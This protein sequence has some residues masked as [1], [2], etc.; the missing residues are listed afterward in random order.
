M[1][2]W[3]EIPN[4]DYRVSNEGRVAKQRLGALKILGVAR[5]SEGYPSVHLREN[6]RERLVKVHVLVAAAFIGPKPSALHEVN[7]KDGI[8]HNN[9]ATNLEWVTRSQ[10]SRHRYDVLHGKASGR[11]K[12]TEVGAREILRRCAAG[13]VQRVI[14]ADYGIDRTTVSCIATGKTW[15]WLDKVTP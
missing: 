6:G 13:E 5:N 8:R 7:H 14:A 3:E 15:A 9:S 1:E 10:N 4:T 2:V 11:R 12:V